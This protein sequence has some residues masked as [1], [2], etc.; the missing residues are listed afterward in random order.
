MA[1]H[2]GAV[3][4]RW[5]RRGHEHARV[6]LLTADPLTDP[7]PLVRADPSSPILLGRDEQGDEISVPLERM[8][9]AIL[10]G[11]TRSGKSSLLYSILGQ[12][13]D[14]A[15]AT[16]DAIVAGLDPS[17][18][19]LRP[20]R[21]T[22][23][24]D[25]QVCGLADLALVESLL[26]RLVDQMDSRIAAIP[27]D[28]DTAI[29]GP[30]NP[31]VVVVIEELPALLRALDTDDTKRGKRCRALIA[32][33]ISESHK[34]GYRLVLV[35]QRAEAGLIDGTVRAQA[36]LRISMRL[37]NTDSVRLL[38]PDADPGLCDEH[39]RAE[40]GV[41]LLSMPGRPLGRFRA[42]W[43]GGYPAYVERVNRR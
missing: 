9:H 43:A 20:F 13:A 25:W 37:D 16:S 36:E 41:G 15:R 42:S 24:A 22:V 27:A 12:V 6:E 39:T 2:L 38:H 32:R 10:A 3:A 34:C 19:T 4:L 18:I 17:G 5:E 21:G 1:P 33:L 31:L 8:P 11:N 26:V 30:E 29:T 23:H 40:P 28:R 14:R 7:I 35:V